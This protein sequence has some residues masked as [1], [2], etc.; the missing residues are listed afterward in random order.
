MFAYFSNI[1]FKCFP[2]V[3]VLGAAKQIMVCVLNFVYAEITHW[4]CHIEQSV[5]CL[6]AVC[7]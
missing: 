1:L 5:I 7:T 6:K 2:L 3:M 4:V